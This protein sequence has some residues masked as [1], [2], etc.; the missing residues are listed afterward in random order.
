[1][2][3]MFYCYPLA[4]VCSS[5]QFG[6]KLVLGDFYV[7]VQLIYILLVIMCW[8]PAEPRLIDAHGTLRFR[9]TPVENRCNAVQSVPLKRKIQRLMLPISCR[10]FCI[11]CHFH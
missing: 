6:A 2:L 8:P 4:S 1:M 7:T 9:G 11:I 3:V 5:E 10:L